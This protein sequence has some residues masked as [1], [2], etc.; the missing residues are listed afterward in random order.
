MI[1]RT[2]GTIPCLRSPCSTRFR[3]FKLV[4]GF[5]GVL[6]RG[7]ILCPIVLASGDRG[8]FL[9]GRAGRTPVGEALDLAG[10]AAFLGADR[11]GVDLDAQLLGIFG[12][13]DGG[14]LPRIRGAVGAE[15]DDLALGIPGVEAAGGG[16][17]CGADGRA[18][19]SLR[20]FRCNPFEALRSQS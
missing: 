6:Q 12:S 1:P 8:D 13:L 5:E 16:G 2:R 11:H 7:D 18:L 14:D 20:M 9:E 19:L 15:D 3:L 17:D 10:D 4:D